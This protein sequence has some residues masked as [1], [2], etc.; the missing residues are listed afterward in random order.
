MNT[1]R[2]IDPTRQTL[3]IETCD[4]DTQLGHWENQRRC[5]GIEGKTLPVDMASQ[6]ALIAERDR[7]LE[8]ICSGKF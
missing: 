4:L 7:V 6:A 5:A 3:R 1:K 8:E 2:N